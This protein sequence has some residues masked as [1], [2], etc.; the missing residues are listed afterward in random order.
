VW[1]PV[2]AET[3]QQF[4]LSDADWPLVI[5]G[6]DGSGAS[7]FTVAL[8]AALVRTGAKIVWLCTTPEG[9]LALQRELHLGEPDAKYRSMTDRAET[10]VA[11]MPVVTFCHRQP[12]ELL[13]FLRSL[14]DWNQRIVILKNMEVT[15]DEAMLNVLRPHRRL[16]LSGNAERAASPLRDLSAGMRIGFSAWPGDWHIER[17]TLPRYV[18]QIA[19]SHRHVI[20]AEADDE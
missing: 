20:A 10:I 8:T 14:R 4:R 7:F 6:T 11:A 18:G 12:G 1:H 5:H 9:V 16:I 13:N 3:D 2:E 19:G 17:G 15:A